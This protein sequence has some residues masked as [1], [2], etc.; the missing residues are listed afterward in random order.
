[1]KCINKCRFWAWILILPLLLSSCGKKVPDP[2]AYQVFESSVEYGITKGSTPDEI[3]LFA[4]RLCIPK[5]KNVAVKKVDSDLAEAGCVFNETTGTVLYA[6]NI[7]EKKYP[8]STT[9]ILTAYVA[10]KYGD[11]N[12]VYT[13]TENACAQS[14]DSTVAGLLPGDK[15]TLNDLLYGMMLVS[16]ND[17]A[18]A[19][20]EGISGDT[21]RFV[22]LMNE[23]A[24][25]LGA[26]HSHFV[27]PNGLHD[28]EHYTCV[29]DMYLIFSAAIQKKKF[30]SLIDKATYT[31]N[32]EGKD[33]SARQKTWENTNGYL[34][35]EYA[36]PEGI[37]IVGGKTGTTSQAGSC[38]VLFSRNARK[39]KIISIVFHADYRYTL[40]QFMSQLLEL[41]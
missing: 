25:R 23:E 3:G 20:A 11:L 26:T 15:I 40:F 18:I 2:N 30:V 16:G 24:K 38:L 39:E 41:A 33:G 6:K 34:T 14:S 31:A 29:Y 9:K 28:D 37:S 1:M 21:K 35:G 22:S 8:A 17:A 10:L 19:I 12:E 27:T 5:E 36:V 32:F 4:D 13:I 7:F